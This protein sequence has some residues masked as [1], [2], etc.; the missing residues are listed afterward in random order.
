[1]TEVQF[2]F[3]LFFWLASFFFTWKFCNLETSL[4]FSTVPVAPENQPP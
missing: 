3:V 1:M 2:G 4:D